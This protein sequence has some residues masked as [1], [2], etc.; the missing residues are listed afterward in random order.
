MDVYQHQIA[1][2]HF[3]SLWSGVSVRVYAHT[4]GMSSSHLSLRH[5]E[6]NANLTPL[7]KTK[8]DFPELFQ[9]RVKG[10]LPT[11]TN[12]SCF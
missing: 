10:P 8:I 3:K 5:F 2:N 4:E 9:A 7:K 11:V 1:A 12:K 6:G